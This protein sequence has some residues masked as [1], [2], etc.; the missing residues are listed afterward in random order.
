MAILVIGN[1]HKLGLRQIHGYVP[2]A[3]FIGEP[4][5]SHAVVPRTRR[6]SDK[7]PGCLT[8]QPVSDLLA[9]FS[10]SWDYGWVQAALVRR[11]DRPKLTN[12][13]NLVAM[14]HYDPPVGRTLQ[15][16]RQYTSG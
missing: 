12:L 14:S 5:S 2:F 15:P 9:A 6:G 16:G 7:N 8:M 10:H 1:C 13:I 3:G 4:F 11:S